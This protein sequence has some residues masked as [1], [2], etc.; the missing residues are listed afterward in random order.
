MDSMDLKGI[1][2]VGHIYQK[3]E[4][5][6]LEIEEAMCQETAKYVENQVQTVGAGMKR[7]CSDVMQDMIP[8]S[9]KDLSKVDSA[10]LILNPYLEFEI[11][12]KPIS[13]IKENAINIKPVCVKGISEDKKS[14]SSNDDW[15]DWSAASFN[16]EINDKDEEN[17]DLLSMKALNKTPVTT[18]STKSSV[19]VVNRSRCISSSNI[20]RAKRTDT[21]DRSRLVSQE[22]SQATSNKLS[23]QSADGD[24]SHTDSCENSSG[25]MSLSQIALDIGANTQCG[26]S[27][28]DEVLKPQPHPGI[29]AADCDPDLEK[30][31]K[32]DAS[33]QIMEPF[34]HEFETNFEETC[35]LV[36]GN[37]CRPDD[38][39]EEIRRSYKKKIQNAFSLKKKS[40]RKQEYKQLAGQY[41]IA[42]A[43]S[44]KK[45]DEAISLACSQPKNIKANKLATHDSLESEWEIL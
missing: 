37:D 39:N 23:S 14:N 34:S 43:E 8:P 1:A 31:A 41:S 5:M 45:C 13:N 24:G 22:V 12:K 42:N 15:V 29:L 25:H 6:C 28:G 27:A 38:H 20:L 26:Q 17:C 3:F 21:C 33:I 16:W 18:V 2:W 10:D 19:K 7:F 35:V 30:E 11:H 36:D 40:A 32:I 4:A 9:S 44:N